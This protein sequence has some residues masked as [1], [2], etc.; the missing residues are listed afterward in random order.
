M[1]EFSRE[2]KAAV[3]PR[4]QA[5]MEQELDLD[6]GQFEAE[7]L[8]DFFIREVGPAFYNRALY[9]AQRVLQQQ[10]DNLAD[11]LYQLEQDLPG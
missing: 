8:L 6:L 1:I 4:I 9:D 2:Q 7:F 11:S 10:F 3:I 5:Y